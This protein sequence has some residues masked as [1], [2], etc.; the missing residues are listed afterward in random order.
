M[1]TIK[2]DEYLLL[3]ALHQVPAPPLAAAHLASMVRKSNLDLLAVA[4]WLTLVVPD[5]TGRLGYRPTPLFVDQ[6]LLREL[7]WESPV[8]DGYAELWERDVLN[9]I[10]HDSSRRGKLSA[11]CLTKNVGR[12]LGVFGLMKSTREDDWVP[13]ERLLNLLVAVRTQHNNAGKAK[14]VK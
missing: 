10:I 12:F 7:E 2:T 8:R 5:K 11:H 9:K 6:I 3:R 1:D 4:E 14:K 13:T